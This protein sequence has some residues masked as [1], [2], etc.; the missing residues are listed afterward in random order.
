MNGTEPRTAPGRHPVTVLIADDNPVV[1]QG[2]RG[3]LDL[4][5]TVHVVGEAWDGQGAIDLSRKL[6]PDVVLLDV[7]MPRR[8]G[9]SALAD[10]VPYSRVLMTTY[11]DDPTVVREAVAYGASGY[12]VHGEFGVGELLAGIHAVAK[13]GGMFSAPAVEA[14]RSSVDLQKPQRTV[15]PESVGVVLGLSARQSEVMSLI[16][17]GLS[18]PEI[19][20]HFFLSEKTVKNHINRIFAALGVTRRAEAIARWHD[21]SAKA[22]ART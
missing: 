13:G 3:L 20:K 22:S 16:A 21:A 2:L 18:N 10:I 9:V 12:L 14:L 17:D 19:A 1:R 6:L 8:D 11:T 7:R 4:E 5:D 15:D